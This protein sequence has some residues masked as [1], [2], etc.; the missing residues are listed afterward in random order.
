MKFHPSTALGIVVWYLMIPPIGADN[1]VDA[2]APLSS[3]RKGVSFNS[4]KECD[5]SLKDAIENPMTP[6]EYQAAAKATRKAKMHPLSKSEMTKRT[7]E[8]L[9]VAGD[10]PRLKGK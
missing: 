8:S 10:D 9:C 2:H 5:E 3:W 4:Q 6:D 7:A 1:K